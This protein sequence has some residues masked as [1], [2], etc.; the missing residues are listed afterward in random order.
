MPRAGA[1]IHMTISS[2]LRAVSA[3]GY[4]RHCGCSRADAQRTMESPKRFVHSGGSTDH[5]KWT[6]SKESWTLSRMPVVNS[7]SGIRGPRWKPYI[8][9]KIERRRIG[10][11][12]QRWRWRRRR[13]I[14]NICTA[15]T[16]A[17]S[18]KRSQ[19]QCLAAACSDGVGGGDD[20]SEI[21][22]QQQ[23]RR[24]P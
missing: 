3:L 23:R 10:G 15:A 6:Q 17:R 20:A 18:M 1:L 12:L 8:Q 24:A 11:C 14:R 4:R 19:S 2:C 16:Q 5:G 9:R 7:P 22:A 21:S 13:R